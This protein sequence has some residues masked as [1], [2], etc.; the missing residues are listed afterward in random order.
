M[1]TF[2]GKVLPGNK[3]GRLLNFPTANVPLT[4][5]IPE[6]IYLSE[7]VI[8]AI[9]YPSLTF[10]GEAK[11]YD[12]H[13]YQSETYLLNFDQDIYDK[14]ITVT[15]HRKLRDNKKFNTEDAL[16][17]QMEEDKKQAEAYFQD[18]L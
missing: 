10:I 12:E 15:L 4:Q 9:S 11:T 3:R 8:E 2:S 16:V 14:T 13:V 1:H 18:K 7:T 5:S 17:R 6:G